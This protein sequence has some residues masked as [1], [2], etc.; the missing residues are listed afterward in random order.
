MKNQDGV[1]EP[2]TSDF[3]N[4]A[5][6]VGVGNGKTTHLSA[7]DG[8]QPV[9]PEQGRICRLVHLMFTC[10]EIRRPV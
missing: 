4:R 7:N 9:E 8:M 6:T 5:S 1:L 10:L 2:G 3:L